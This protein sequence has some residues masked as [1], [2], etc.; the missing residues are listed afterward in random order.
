[1]P[2]GLWSTPVDDDGGKRWAEKL[3]GPTEGG[4]F[5]EALSDLQL[6]GV[7]IGR[8]VAPPPFS[9]MDRDILIDTLAPS[10]QACITAGK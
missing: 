2:L 1:M 3:V 5:R 8:Y 4:P 7:A 6:L 9:N 10:I